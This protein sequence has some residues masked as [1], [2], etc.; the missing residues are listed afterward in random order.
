MKIDYLHQRRKRHGLGLRDRLVAW[1]PRY[2][3]VA[4]RARVGAEP[5]R[6]GSRA[7]RRHRAPPG[8]EREASAAAL[9]E[10]SVPG[11]SRTGAGRGIIGPSLSAGGRCV[12]DRAR[13]PAG[14]SRTGAGRDVRTD[15]ARAGSASAGGHGAG[16]AFHDTGTPL[17]PSVGEREATGPNHP[18]SAHGDGSEVVLFADT[19]NTWFEPENARAAVRVLEAA[20]VPGPRRRAA[21][22]RTP[23]AV[24]RAD[25]PRRRLDRG[26]P[27]RAGADPLG[28]R[29]VHR[30]RSPSS[31]W[32]PLPAYVP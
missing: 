21:A 2:A 3:P 13:F 11:R 5:A 8:A 23:P 14:G 9:A 1:L 16:P 24:L 30:T 19:F 32:S 26:S 31:A 22:G 25:V 28:A 18:V 7:R 20:G 27:I 29:A 15:A 12:P 4:S 10:R 6:P 17:P